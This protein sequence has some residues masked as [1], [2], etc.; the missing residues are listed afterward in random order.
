[1]NQPP[2]IIVGA[3]R[4]GTKLLRRI[5]TASPGVVCFPR[6]IN[7]VW[8]HGNPLFPTD[9]LTPS[10]A[11]PKVIRYIRQR[12]EKFSQRHNGRR[13]V[14]K[15][16]A[17]VLR[18]EYVHAIFPEAYII[19]LVRDG[20]AVAESAQ[21][22]WQA[23]PD[24]HYLLEKARWLPLTDIPYYTWRYVR[25]QLGRLGTGNGAQASW[26]PRFNGLDQLVA[27]KTLI[28]VCG[29]QWKACVRGAEQAF[30]NLP[31]CQ[32]ISVRY[33]D[34]VNQPLLTAKQIY[35]KVRLDFTSECETYIN[36]EMTRSNLTKWKQNLTPRDL[37]LL[38]PHIQTEL[39]QFGYQS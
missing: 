38:L 1:M 37:E 17:N 25:Y 22:R 26:G 19:H 32:V 4:S 29:L 11:R 20:R 31:D 3:G 27:E 16:C 18:V 10:H 39:R 13:I 21:R 35:E 8:R 6:E 28:E 23:P 14:E 12:F 24:A 5:L 34:L 15:T 2:I 33:E 36:H 30:E 7:Y 9:E